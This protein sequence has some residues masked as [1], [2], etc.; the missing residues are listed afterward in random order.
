MKF[1]K[2][3]Q[4]AIAL[5]KWCEREKIDVVSG[6][7]LVQLAKLA[8]TAGESKCT[9]NTEAARTRAENARDR[10][11]AEAGLH[12]YT[13]SWPGLWPTLTRYGVEIHIPDVG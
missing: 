7:R 1:S 9:I 11:D 2:N 4:K 8:H 5:A 6:A 13:V 10:F 12:G 3:L